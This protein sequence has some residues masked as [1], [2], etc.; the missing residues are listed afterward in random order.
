MTWI[1][2][3]GSLKES[4]KR[5]VEENSE[6]LKLPEDGE[7]KKYLLRASLPVVEIGSYENKPKK[8]Y[9]WPAADGRRKLNVSH[10]L[11]LQMLDAIEKR[12]LEIVQDKSEDILFEITRQGKG[13]STAWFVFVKGGI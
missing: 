12:K 8:E 1:D 3:I 9:S 5:D 2:G 4:I 6:Y 7:T 10:K 13:K 11:C